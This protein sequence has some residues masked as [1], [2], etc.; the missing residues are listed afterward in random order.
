MASK[1]SG[2]GRGPVR[3]NTSPA[4]KSIAGKVLETGKA[5]PRQAR[6]LAGSVMRHEPPKKGPRK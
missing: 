4:V 1:S 5:T 2:T 3:P 6:A